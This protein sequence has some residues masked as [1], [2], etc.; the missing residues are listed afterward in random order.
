M[1][2]QLPKVDQIGFANGRSVGFLEGL[3]HIV[4]V[5]EEEMATVNNTTRVA[6][7]SKGQLPGWWIVTLSKCLGGECGLDR[8]DRPLIQQ[9]SP[10]D[11]EGNKQL[12]VKGE[13]VKPTQPLVPGRQPS[14]ALVKKERKQQEG[15]HDGHTPARSHP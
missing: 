9:P 13:P 7:V 14:L 6:L 3:K 11:R 2:S 4:T 8:I 1:V 5:A 12:S 10:G 15:R